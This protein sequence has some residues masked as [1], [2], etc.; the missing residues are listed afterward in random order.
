M[1]G[2]V[3]SSLAPGEEYAY[4]F[5]GYFLQGALQPDNPLE[6]EVIMIYHNDEPA[7]DGGRG[8]HL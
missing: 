8:I 6:V 3:Y 1:T 5:A 2:C 7:V 4:D